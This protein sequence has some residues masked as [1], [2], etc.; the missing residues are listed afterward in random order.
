MPEVNDSHAVHAPHRPLEAYYSGEEGRR[1]FLRRIF[2]EAAGDY[3]LIER[4][5]ALGSGSRYRRRA[6][7]RAGLR[8]GMAVLDVA[9]GTGLVAREAASVL[10]DR[11]RV[12]GL[13]PSSGMLHA[14]S[15]ELGTSAVQGTAESLPFASASFDFLSMGFALRH[16]TDLTV[17]F[18]EFR[19]V[20]RPGGVVCLLE[21]TQPNGRFARTVTK[22]YM[23]RIAPLVARAFARHAET[24]RLM[25][26]YW[27][28]I[29]ACVPPEEVLAA[30]RDAGFT[31]V[32]RHVE[33]R[34]FSEY[35]GRVPA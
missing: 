29:E 14:A 16:M 35:T 21:I 20:L 22:L 17:V 11:A 2:D 27:D 3:D 28:T 12:V 5:M 4:V 19:R 23:R 32:R 30:L 18:S 8:P 25:R 24:A 33:L 13:D 7:V 1:P 34:I 10:G 26:Y 15:S 6:L 31:D 9:T